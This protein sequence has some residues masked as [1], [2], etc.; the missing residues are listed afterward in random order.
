M[1][2]RY[3]ALDRS[4][5][6]Y[7]LVYILTWLWPIPY[8]LATPYQTSAIFAAGALLLWAVVT[9]GCGIAA[10]VALLRHDNLV[11]ERYAL[12]VFR[13]LT[14]LFPAVSTVTLVLELAGQGYSQRW[15]ATFLGVLPFVVLTMRQQMLD[16]K[17]KQVLEASL[18][19]AR[20]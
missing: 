16:G 3:R 12:A 19:E 8:A 15:H 13:W 10:T 6:W 11:L 20:A 14:L 9:T 1:I 5:R 18:P 4:G 7:L 2:S 17:A